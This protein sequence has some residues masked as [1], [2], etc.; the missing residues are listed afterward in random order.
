[1]DELSRTEGVLWVDVGGHLCEGFEIL[2]RFE[3][4]LE[5][6]EGDGLS[7]VG[8]GVIQLNLRELYFRMRGKVYR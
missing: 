2:L 3:T 4:V 8:E 6:H 1:M 5:L 7:L